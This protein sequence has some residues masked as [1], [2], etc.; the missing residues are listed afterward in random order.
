MK[1]KFRIVVSI[2]VNR[3]FA[4]LKEKIKIAK[5]EGADVIE[6]RA[7]S[8]PKI[9]VN[10]LLKLK[11]ISNALKIPVIFTLRSK[12]EGG[13][14]NFSF[15]KK[16]KLIEK[17]IELNFE[18]VDIE[19]KF[20]EKLGKNVLKLKGNS[21]I[22]IILSFH[23][24]KGTETL[25][26]LRGIKKRIASLKPD[27]IKLA[28]FSRSEK[29]NQDILKII[30]ETKREGKDIV[31]IALGER[32]KKIRLKSAFEGNYLT[33]CCLNKKEKTAPGQL[34]LNDFKKLTGV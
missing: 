24:L 7:D 30:K 21:K 5:L 12:E 32:G 4:Q 2:F 16:L 18:Y 25:E 10:D 11:K 1:K 26:G 20:L 23:N 14:Y 33:Y 27:I 13:K 29:T 8:Y 31:G 22:K 34:T 3:N 9:S 28:V 15:E 6:L 17:A 19:L